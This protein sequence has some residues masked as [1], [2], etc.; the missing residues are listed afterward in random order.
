MFT[1]VLEIVSNLQQTLPSPIFITISICRYISTQI[2]AVSYH[3]D[4][5]EFSGIICSLCWYW[6]H[7][8]LVLMM[9]H[10]EKRNYQMVL[11]IDFD[12][13]N[14]PIQNVGY[15]LCLMIV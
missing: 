13:S 3:I 12:A 5:L 14:L 2:A 1:P 11:R 10:G 8:N 15:I 6:T 4:F 7:M 9:P